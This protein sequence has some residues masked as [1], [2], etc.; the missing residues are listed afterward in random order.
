M[1]TTLPLRP[2]ILA[3][4][5]VTLAA[6]CASLP[7]T[8]ADQF[9]IVR[10]DGIT[11]DTERREVTD[12]SRVWQPIRDRIS[13]YIGGA[14]GK[15]ERP[16]LILHVHG[17]LNTYSGALERIDAML[18]AQTALDPAGQPANKQ[19]AQY[20][21]LFLNWDSSL[22]TSVGDDL[23]TLR[24]GEERP[25]LGIPSSPFITGSR[26][27]TSGLG[28]PQSLFS[29]LS[30]ANDALVVRESQPWGSVRCRKGLRAVATMRG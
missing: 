23:F 27:A 9:I 15:G 18:A 5:L 2:P 26:L 30:N 8:H 20:H 4:L 17:G 19:L 25:L 13:Q 16:R 3:L 11:I 7:S 29:Q 10:K 14:S 21:F 24:L 6:G 12:F 22:L 1:R 28:A